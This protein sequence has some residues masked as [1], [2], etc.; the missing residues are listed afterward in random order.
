MW[1]FQASNAQKIAFGRGSAPDHA[2]ELIRRSP[3]PSRLGR[4]NPLST[5]LPSTPSLDLGAYVASIARPLPVKIHG[6]AYAVYN[7]QLQ[8]NG[9]KHSLPYQSNRNVLIVVSAV[10][11]VSRLIKVQFTGKNWY[12]KSLGSPLTLHQPLPPQ[13]NDAPVW[14]R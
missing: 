9:N 5:L 10:T 3:D 1:H 12:Q 6:Y 11:L 13:K 2:W 8:N 14:A 7:M 4:G